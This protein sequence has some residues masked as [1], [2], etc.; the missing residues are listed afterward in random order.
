MLQARSDL[1]A[2]AEKEFEALGRKGFPG[3]EF[4]DVVQ[5]RQ[6]LM[7][8]DERGMRSDEIEGRLG[9]KPGVVEKLGKRGLVSDVGAMEAGKESGAALG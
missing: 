3:R 1:A 8:R 5:I 4:L 9:L 2:R 6:V 7:M